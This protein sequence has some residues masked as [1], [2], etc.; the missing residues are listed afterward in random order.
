[1][2]A[3]NQSLVS[4]NGGEV[5]REIIARTNL[6]TYPAS[7][8]R[9]ENFIPDTVGQ[10]HL[11]PG[12]Q[13]KWEVEDAEDAALYTFKFNNQQAYGL[14]L[15]DLLMRITDDGLPI[16]RLE[17]DCSITNDEFASDISSWTDITEASSDDGTGGSI[18]AGGSGGGGSS[19][20]S[21]GGS[22]GGLMGGGGDPGGG[23]GGSPGGDGGEGGA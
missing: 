3:V 5:G 9:M 2:A 21:S 19:G 16:T 8:S 20:G 23:G 7:A 4:F 1:V 6:E 13:F 15:T 22:G 17:V 10:M 14:V 11:R 12:L 18:G